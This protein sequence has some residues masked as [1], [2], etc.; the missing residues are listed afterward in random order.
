MVRGADAR[1]TEDTSVDKKTLQVLRY[2]V[3][4]VSSLGPRTSPPR[5]T[6]A[7]TLDRSATLA[8]HRGVDISPSASNRRETTEPPEPKF[9]G[10]C[11]PSAVDLLWTLVREGGLEPPHPKAHGPE[12]CASANSATRANLREITR[13]CPRVRN[14][15]ADAPLRIPRNHHLHPPRTTPGPAPGPQR[16]AIGKAQKS[17]IQ[18]SAVSMKQIRATRC[19]LRRAL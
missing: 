17:D 10:F 7:A 1:L 11:V 8:T 12:P 5:P 18:P 3:L 14:R 15:R 16:K 2:R 9:R 4:E 6:R 19:G 13:H